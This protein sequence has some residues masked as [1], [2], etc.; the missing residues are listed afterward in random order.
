ME[1]LTRDY[2]KSFGGASVLMRKE[3]SYAEVNLA[4]NQWLAG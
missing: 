2:V 4:I 3:R 1:Q